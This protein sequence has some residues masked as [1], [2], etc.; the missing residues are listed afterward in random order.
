MIRIVVLMF[1]AQ[2]VVDFVDYKVSRLERNKTGI[3]KSLDQ[4]VCW[5]NTGAD[6]RYDIPCDF[7]KIFSLLELQ[8]SWHLHHLGTHK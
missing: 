1:V 7:S 4:R 5:I 2:K 8:E 6:P 3:D